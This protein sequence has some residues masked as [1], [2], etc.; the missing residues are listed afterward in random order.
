MLPDRRTLG[1]VNPEVQSF[2]APSDSRQ[3]KPDLSMSVRIEK[4]ALGTDSLSGFDDALPSFLSQN[5]HP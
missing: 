2:V 5:P 1:F 3:S 4:T